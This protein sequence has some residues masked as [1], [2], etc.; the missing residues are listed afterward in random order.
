MAGTTKA[1]EVPFTL[2]DTSGN[3]VFTGEVT[4]LMTTFEMKPPTAVF[5]TIKAGDEVK[6]RFEVVT[7]KPAFA[8]A[9]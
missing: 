4:M 7:A 9:Q 2:D 6:V 1:V 8:K 3:W 5:G